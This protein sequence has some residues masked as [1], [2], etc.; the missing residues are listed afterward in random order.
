MALGDPALDDQ[1]L[2]IA[3]WLAQPLGTV[4]VDA[5]C[6]LF[7]PL[8]RWY[9][10]DS[11]LQAGRTSPYAG[12]AVPWCAALDAGPRRFAEGLGHFCSDAHNLEGFRNRCRDTTA[13]G[14]R[15]CELAY[16]EADGGA[17]LRPLLGWHGPGHNGKTLFR[18]LWQRLRT[19]Y[20]STAASAPASATP[21]SGVCG[22]T[23]LGEG[24][25]RR[26][27]WG[28]WRASDFGITLKGSDGQAGCLSLCR[29]CARCAYV[30]WSEQADECA[31]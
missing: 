15:R 25:C 28:S 19:N 27:W 22:V 31:F 17:A 8:A 3:Y 30:S 13:A 7:C 12:R 24:D 21:A 2:L 14:G 9:V 6:S 5:H 4:V 16:A 10:L 29:Q 1:G 18:P 11:E 20:W 23:S 26:G